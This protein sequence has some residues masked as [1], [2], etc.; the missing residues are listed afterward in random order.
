[1]GWLDDLFSGNGQ[2]PAQASPFD[3]PKVVAQ[4]RQLLSAAVGGAGDLVGQSTAQRVA[5]NSAPM[6]PPRPQVGTPYTAPSQPPADVG[7]RNSSNAKPPTPARASY[8]RGFGDVMQDFGSA[9][10][11]KDNRSTESAVRALIE[12]KPDMTPQMARALV[13]NPQLGQVLLP[14]LFPGP[15]S[16][17]TVIEDEDG[18]KLIWD[19]SAQT[20]RPLTIGASGGAAAI[21]GGGGQPTPTGG[22]QAPPGAASQ[23]PPGVNR[24]VYKESLSREMAQGQAKAQLALPNSANTLQQ[25]SENIDK[26]LT[27]PSL[28]KVIG[29]VDSR[30]YTFMPKSVEAESILDQIKGQTFLTAYDSLRGAGAIT[31]QEGAA[32]K[33]A[34]NRL[35][36]TDMGEKEYRKALGEFKKEVSVL[37]DIVQRK[38]RGDFTPPSRGDYGTGG[39]T[40]GAGYKVLGVR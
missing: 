16:A 38:A 29:P 14:Q 4:I 11:G 33:A 15:K 12:L 2:Q 5:D 20:Y 10:Q 30:T 27:H 1:M 7:P 25:I 21:P 34:Y 3:D 17:P 40:S 8:S 22:G 18:R 9:L 13:S 23:P 37:Q 32:A 36:R 31:E 24:K 39:G 19:A 26:A 28:D 35:Q 6:T